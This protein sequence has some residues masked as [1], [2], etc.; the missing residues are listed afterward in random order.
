MLPNFPFLPPLT[1]LTPFRGGRLPAENQPHR[2]LEYLPLIQLL[3]A[4]GVVTLQLL[5]LPDLQHVVR[6][7][8]IDVLLLY[9]TFLHVH[10]RQQALNS[11]TRITNTLHLDVL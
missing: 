4:L 8:I 11:P 2:Y 9:V 5:L 3:F 10:Q 1:P 6:L 7:E